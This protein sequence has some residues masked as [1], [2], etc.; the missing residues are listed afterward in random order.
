MDK[1]TKVA[2]FLPMNMKTPRDKLARMYMKKVITI[3]GVPLSIVSDRDLRFLGKFWTELQEALGT[4][5]NFSTAYHPQTDGQTERTNQTLED[6]LRACVL[7]FGKDWQKSLP[8]CEF[9]Y[10]NSYHSN[11]GMAPF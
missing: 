2:H 10:N 11:I 7:D 1:L 6:L 4:T 9:A 3:H 8:L 5:L